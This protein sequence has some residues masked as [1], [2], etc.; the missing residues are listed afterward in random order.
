[1]GESYM[2]PASIIRDAFRLVFAS[3]DF[4][5]YSLLGI[6]YELF[7]N[8]ASAEII[9]NSTVM[10]FF[11][12]VQLILGVFMMFQLAMTI[13]KGIV[14]PDSFTDAKSGAG[15]LITRII[16][17]LILLTLLI[18]INI[19]NASN[20][21]EDQVRKNG[22]LFGTLYS[23]Q[24]RLL[25]NNT[26]GKLIFGNVSTDYV[27]ANSNMSELKK[28]SKVFTST[29]LKSFYRI[30]L[31][32]ESQRKQHQEGK[33]D[34]IFNANRVCQDI[35]DSKL[36]LY[37]KEDADPDDVTGMVNET[38]TVSG[39]GILGTKYYAFSYMPLVSLIVGIVFTF[40]LLSFSVDVAVRAIKLA[41]LRL[42]APIPIIGYMD[43]KGSKDSSFNAWTKAVTSTYLDLFIRL[44]AVYFVIFLISDIIRNG[45]V[46][47]HGG[48]LL[49]ALTFILIFIGLFVFAKQAPKFIKEV[50]GLKG[51]TGNIF[52]GLGNILG[53]LTLGASTVGSFN[54]SRKASISS[55]VARGK[56]PKSILN[57]GKH[58]LAGFA[59]AGLGAATGIRAW[60]GAK[61]HY[62]KAIFDAMQKRNATAVE[63]GGAGS[64][65]T[66]RAKAA[67]ARTFQGEGA[68]SFDSKTREIAQLKGIEKSGNDLF[69]YLEGKGKTD[70]ANYEVETAEL[71]DENGKKFTVKGTL[72]KFNRAKSAA[73]ID[74]QRG[75][76]NGEFVFDGRSYHVT[77]QIL[78]KIEDELSYAAGDEWARLEEEKQAKW[79]QAKKDHPELSDEALK[80]NLK[81]TEGDQGY[82]QK[83]QTYNE[84]VLNVEG[85]YGTYNGTTNRKS[86]SSLKKMAKKA[87]GKALFEES[88]A[89]YQ[90]QK[91]DFNATGKK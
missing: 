48:G 37:T 44:G 33:D 43:P 32:P 68:T 59:G 90:R 53:G 23:L 42:I 69:K 29:V 66:G 46:I 52:G 62:S 47:N 74:Q 3:L 78:S 63:R 1:M 17:A 54:A 67:M 72:N 83:K 75:I 70:G 19:P 87:G 84:S 56:D 79:L 51:D 61:D 73:L 24:H 15:N 89:S 10:S 71:T 40:I 82:L 26:I 80:A 11:G 65:V 16:T 14:N 34:A 18:P 21:Y 45:L 2:Q 38:C 36:S 7:F 5:V 13:L 86:V 6:V 76:G 39:R 88:Q 50:L 57:Q 85:E 4:V 20:E 64:T 27:S 81:V 31:L 55:D 8:V 12:R 58:L 35:D 22:I 41:V 77:D 49:G 28:S 60:N 30:N 25:A 9:S 91:A